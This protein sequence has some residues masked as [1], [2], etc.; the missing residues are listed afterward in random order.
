MKQSI[1]TEHATTEFIQDYQNAFG[2]KADLPL[3]FWYSSKP[4]LEIPKTK[5]CFLRE[6]AAA[7]DGS[8]ISLS[9]KNISC[10]GGKVYCGYDQAPPFISEFVSRKEKYKQNPELVT[11][12]LKE[13]DPPKAPEPYLNITR[14]DQMTSFDKAEGVLFFASPDI[15]SGLISWTLFDTNQNDAV[16]VPFGSGCSSLITRVLTENQNSGSRSFLGL[17]D[18]SARIWFDSDILSLGVPMSRFQK[19]AK[20]IKESC[21]SQT[22]A[23][24]K[25]RKRIMANS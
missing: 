17:F 8:T 9:R 15:L 23:W 7:R 5:G 3:V 10:P 19:M 6:L 24:T 14:I 11:E 13:I 1:T 18:P 21:L 16:S 25:I 2:K 4:V 20:T 22:P 12:F